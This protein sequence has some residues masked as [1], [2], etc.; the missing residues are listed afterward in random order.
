MKTAIW[1][2]RS[3]IFH[4]RVDLLKRNAFIGLFLV[5]GILGLFLEVRLAFWVTMGIPISFLGSFLFLPAANVSINMISLFAFIITLGMVVDDAIVIGES[6]YVHRQTHSDFI[7]A[8][9][10][11]AD[12]VATPVIFSIFTSMTAFAPMF[13]VEGTMGKVFRIL[14]SVVI[15]VLLLSLFES[16]YILPAHLGHLPRARETGIRGWLYRLQQR[17]GRLVE[18][19]AE[20]IYGPMV[21]WAVRNHWITWALGIFLLLIAVGFVRGGRISI[22]FFPKIESDWVVTTAMLPYGAS[23]EDTEKIQTRVEQAVWAVVDEVTKGW[24]DQLCKGVFTGV[25]GRHKMRFIAFLV[26]TDQRDISATQF[27]QKWRE[28]IGH[29]PGLKSLVFDSTAGGPR[30]GSPVDVQLAHKDTHVLEQAAEDLAAA[31]GTY[32]GVTDIDDGFSEG[33]PQWNLTITPEARSLGLTAADLGRQMRSTFWGAEALR[34]QRGRDMIRVMVRL[35]KSERISE[36]DIETLLIRTPEGG[37]S[38]SSRP[39]KLTGARP[40]PASHGPTGGGSSM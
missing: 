19:F 29:L 15:L 33:K 25:R 12:E 35:P 36:Y 24:R 39:Q 21:R 31:L 34:Q 2:D 22:M 30:G 5:L 40:A 4:Q 3:D 37:K 38:R 9:I 11:G 6:I 17:F 8:A 1:R 32:E 14:P 27:A 10:S 26:P 23:P 20:N 16:L 13:F 28:K 18:R 7:A